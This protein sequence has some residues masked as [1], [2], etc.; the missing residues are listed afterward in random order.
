M[1]FELIGSKELITAMSF[2]KHL[3]LPGSFCTFSCYTM[4]MKSRI[5]SKFMVAYI[6]KMHQVCGVSTSLW[7]VVMT[8]SGG[9]VALLV[10]VLHC[11]FISIS[12]EY[13]SWPLCLDMYGGCGLPNWSRR[14][15]LHPVTRFYNN[16]RFQVTYSY[17]NGT[18]NGVTVTLYHNYVLVT[19]TQLS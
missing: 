2:S 14:R 3:V 13:N 8:M 5:Y 4:F 19:F 9:Y 17:V 1:I 11:W 16:F 10:N 18:V 12:T 7:G 15:L 6:C